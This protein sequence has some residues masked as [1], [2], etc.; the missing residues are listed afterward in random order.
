M[1]SRGGIFSRGDFFEIG[2]RE[3]AAVDR[4]KEDGSLWLVNRI[5]LSKG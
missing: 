3:H 1:V 4:A 5:F 2:G